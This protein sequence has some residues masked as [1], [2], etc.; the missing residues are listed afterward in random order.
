MALIVVGP[1]WAQAG[2]EGLTF[3]H[4]RPPFATKSVTIHKDILIDGFHT[5]LRYIPKSIEV[6]IRT[7]ITYR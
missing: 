2:V 1:T 6:P 7:V 4:L 3:S 5:G